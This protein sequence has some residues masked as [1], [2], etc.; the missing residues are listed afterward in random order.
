MKQD[1]FL[2]LTIAA[3]ITLTGILLLLS[4]GEKNRLAHAASQFHGETIERGAK[5]YHDNCRNCH[6]IKG[7]G[8]GQLGPPLNNS[9]FFTQRLSEVGYQG[10]L[11]QYVHTTTSYGRMMGTRQMYAGN[12]STA[13]MVP[14][15]QENGGPLRHDELS[16]ITEFVL[17]WEATATGKIVFEELVLPTSNLHDLKVVKRGK[18]VF[19]TNCSSCHQY[20]PDFNNGAVGPDLT[21]LQTQ[22]TNRKS[23]LSFEEHLR[24]S[25]L[26]PMDNIA[27]GY[28][29]VTEQ[30]ACGAILTETELA[31]VTGYLSQ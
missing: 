12:G 27:A 25:V 8:V 14:W 1:F 2:S 15:S 23:M 29:G 19:H 5:L 17:N 4:Y 9:S 16:D 22:F 7:E 11:K 28:K 26:L 30:Q 18:T 24:H 20:Q 31:A 10:T 21:E 6:G 13:V 3:A